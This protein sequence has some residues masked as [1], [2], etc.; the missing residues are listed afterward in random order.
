MSRG[1]GVR[2]TPAICR[3]YERKAK[4]R[5]PVWFPS[6]WPEMV[7]MYRRE[8]AEARHRRAQLRARHARAMRERMRTLFADPA[9][10]ARW[11]AAHRRAVAAR[12]L[13]L[14]DILLRH[15]HPES[16][17]GCWLWLGERHNKGYGRFRHQQAHRFVFVALGHRIPRGYDLHHLCGNRPCVRPD[18]LQPV[19]PVVHG[20][21]SAA[22]R[23]RDEE[24]V[25]DPITTSR[26]DWR[27]HCGTHSAWYRPACDHCG[28]PQESVA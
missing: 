6:T 27:C 26:P 4:Q 17:G 24:V 20:R 9:W 14:D 13:T 23:W 8:L 11:S 3:W 5:P 15:V 22:V 12:R 16:G 18:H 19:L 25:D 1:A 7:A 21:L 28:A 2:V 10:R